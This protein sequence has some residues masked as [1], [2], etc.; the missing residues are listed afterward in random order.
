MDLP[1]VVDVLRHTF[2]PA[3]HL[4][5]SAEAQLEELERAPGYQACLL[6]IITLA[7]QDIDIRQAA[8]LR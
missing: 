8:V 1:A 2:H 3:Q 4:R 5:Q 6:Q 7:E